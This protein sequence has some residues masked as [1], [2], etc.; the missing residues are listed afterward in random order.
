MTAALLLLSGCAALVGPAADDSPPA[1]FEAMWEAVDERYVL[2]PEKSV[3]W[4]AAGEDGRAQLSDSTDDAELFSVMAEALDALEDG[5]V[6]LVS[7]FDVSRHWDWYLDAPVGYSDEVIERDYLAGQQQIVG[8]LWM[9]WLADGQISYIR[10]SD[11]SGEITGSHLDAALDML[12][13]TQGAILDLRGNGGGDLT[14]AKAVASFFADAA[15]PTHSYVYKEGPGHSDRSAPDIYETA[16]ASQAYTG[17]LVVLTDARSY[18]AASTLAV[19]LSEMPHVTLM[20]DT[21]GGGAG[22]PHY[23]ELPNGWWLRVPTAAIGDGAG[24]LREDGIAPDVAVAFSEA[25]A[26]EEGIDTVIEAAISLLLGG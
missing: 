14:N 9:G 24:V 15:R 22:I 23:V 25:Q 19:M 26:A 4:D 20:G 12:R 13:T 1:T 2:F 10:Y 16:P 17:P 6:N 11:L 7:D 21:T 18:S 8:P 5:H 3:D